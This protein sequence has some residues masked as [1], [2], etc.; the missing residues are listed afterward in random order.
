MDAAGGSSAQPS[1]CLKPASALKILQLFCGLGCVMVVPF[2][3][4]S[5]RWLGE[6]AL[7]A[8]LTK[9][10]LVGW[11]WEFPS[12]L[13]ASGS[14]MPSSED[15]VGTK[16]EGA[17]G[18]TATGSADKSANKIQLTT[19][20]AF[21]QDKS[22]TLQSLIF[23]CTEYRPWIILHDCVVLDAVCVF[24]PSELR[25]WWMHAGRVPHNEACSF[26]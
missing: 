19:P 7:R 2:I 6:P 26:T 22:T 18:A 8:R 17:W 14:G 25:D 12:E 10:L 16:W 9:E 11:K 3:A 4:S 23:I 1:W 20:K 21:S 13:P 24:T 15:W 5:S